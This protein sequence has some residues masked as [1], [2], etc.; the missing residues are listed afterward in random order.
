MGWNP[1]IL[2]DGLKLIEPNQ[3]IKLYPR[4]H[5]SDSC[6]AVVAAK[7]MI[8]KGFN[9]LHKEELMQPP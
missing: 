6:F 7:K 4:I 1:Y 5:T 9:I 3:L 8:D 2:V